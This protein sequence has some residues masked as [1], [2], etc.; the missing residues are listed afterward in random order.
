MPLLCS[1][2][3]LVSGF[4]R[5]SGRSPEFCSEGDRNTATFGPLLSV[6]KWDIRYRMLFFLLQSLHGLFQFSNFLFQLANALRPDIIENPAS[7]PSWPIS[8]KRLFSIAV[9]K[10]I[11]SW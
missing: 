9:K 2:I 8:A 4:S 7:F 5:D 11:R 3:G 6:P 10:A 1:I